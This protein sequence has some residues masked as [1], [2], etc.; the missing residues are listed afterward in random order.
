M[1]FPEH[2]LWP[3]VLAG[4][5]HATAAIKAAPFHKRRKAERQVV[6]AF[7]KDVY[8]G[9][10]GER[11]DLPAGRVSGAEATAPALIQHILEFANQA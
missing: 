1:G 3:M 9:L 6:Y 4:R 7:C 11:P 2:V 5:D 8:G 10:P